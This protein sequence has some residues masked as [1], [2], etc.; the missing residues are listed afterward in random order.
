MGLGWFWPFSSPSLGHDHF[1][2][3]LKS[4]DIHVNNS[5]ITIIIS[6]FFTASFISQSTLTCIITNPHNF[7]RFMRR[8]LECHYPRLTEVKTGPWRIKL[9]AVLVS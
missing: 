8:K 2:R 4:L 7:V 3:L 6:G 9:L 1:P 5:I